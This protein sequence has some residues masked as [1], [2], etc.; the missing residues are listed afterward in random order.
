MYFEKK[1]KNKERKEEKLTSP[2]PESSSV[3][4][5]LCP[6]KRSAPAS[7]SPRLLASPARSRNERVRFIYPILNDV[8]LGKGVVRFGHMGELFPHPSY[9]VILYFSHCALA[10]DTEYARWLEEHNRH[11]SELRA[12]VNSHAG[13]TELSTIVDSV[14][15]HFEDIF[16]LKGIAA[17]ADVFISYR[18]SR[19]PS[20]IPIRFTP[21]RTYRNRWNGAID[22][23]R[24]QSLHVVS[25]RVTGI[26]IE[27]RKTRLER[28]TGRRAHK[29]RGSLGM[30]KRRET[31]RRREYGSQTS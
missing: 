27:W 25:V 18:I 31:R 14:T 23:I 4:G 10:F 12:A 19:T 16:R 17:K 22:P 11:I 15:A 5:E 7:D 28:T 6:S 3:I 20:G 1:E 8:V 21:E 29:R 26:R 24:H 9:L 13:D 2:S 30:R